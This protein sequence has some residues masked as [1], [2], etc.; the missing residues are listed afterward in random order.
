MSTENFVK[1]FDWSEDGR[2]CDCKHFELKSS[3]VAPSRKLL[4]RN[5]RGK[6]AA[7]DEFTSSVFEHSAAYEQCCVH[8]RCSLKEGTH[9]TWVYI[10]ARKKD[11]RLYSQ[12]SLIT[13]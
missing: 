11:L 13:N 12:L 10:V 3:N 1:T 5:N 7:V 4:T 2:K 6:A 9:D 8:F